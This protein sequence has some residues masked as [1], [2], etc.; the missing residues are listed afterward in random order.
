MAKSDLGTAFHLLL[1]LYLAGAG[2]AHAQRGDTEQELRML[3]ECRECLFVDIDASGRRMT[4][5]NFSGSTFTNVNF[6]GAGLNVSIFNGASFENVSFSDADLTGA[7]FSGAT[8]VNVTFE[9]ADLTGAVL[10]GVELE[11]THFRDA[12]L[13]NTRMPN[14]FM[15][16][17]GCGDIETTVY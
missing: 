6:S 1:V 7:S 9:G 11:N 4:G 12:Q 3:G 13:C 14:E 15:N 8:F 10:N 17:S 5:A 2:A 16:R